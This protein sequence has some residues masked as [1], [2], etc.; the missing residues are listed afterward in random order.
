MRILIVKRK[1]NGPPGEEKELS[2]FS[3]HARG[4]LMRYASILSSFKALLKNIKKKQ[5]ENT[6]FEKRLQD[7]IASRETWKTKAKI[8]RREN[9]ALKKRLKELTQSRETWKTKVHQRQ[10]ELAGTKKHLKESQ[11]ALQS[12]RRKERPKNHQYSLLV[13]RLVVMVKLQTSASFRAIGH[14]VVILQMEF[15]LLTETP[16]PTTVAN[17]VYKIGYYELT[18]PKDQAE[19]WIILLDH[20]IQLGQDKLFVVLGIRECQ[21]DFTRPLTY[22]DLTPFVITSKPSWNADDVCASLTAFQNQIGPIKYA[23]GDHSGELKKGVQLAGIRQIHDLTHAI[24]LM[25]EKLYKT[26]DT[27]HALTTQMSAMRTKY[28]QSQLAPLI[29][30]KQRKKSRYQNIKTIA[31]WAKTALTTYESVAGQ[32]SED[33]QRIQQALEWLP[34]YKACIDELATINDIICQ[35]E[36]IVKW[37]GLSKDTVKQCRPILKQLS[38]RSG[39]KGALLKKQLE[40]YFQTTLKL[41]HA[42]N[43]LLCTSDILESAFGKYKNYLSTNPLA[44]VTNLALVI[45]AF[46]SSL[47]KHEIKEALENTTIK[48]I[49]TWTQKHIGTTVFAKRKLLLSGG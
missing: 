27:Y 46:T 4:V 45:A 28:S 29:A 48:D 25:V 18:R 47:E 39:S 23:V 3:R 40:Q 19:D 37:Y 13:I 21:I 7:L 41:I 22:H 33:A 30:P 5:G 8:R 26:D 35:V 49:K 10:A 6:A 24:A 1:M 14:L 34:S 12:T 32:P 11:R 20:S 17:W 9:T 16:T 36:R 31:D 38:T 15:H 2:L 43:Q 42:S 44:G